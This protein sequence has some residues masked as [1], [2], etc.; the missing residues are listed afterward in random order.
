MDS[1]Q[2][3]WV[4]RLAMAHSLALASVPLSQSIRGGF[5]WH[6]LGLSLSLRERVLCCRSLIVVQFRSGVLLCVV[7]FCSSVPPVAPV[8]WV[9]ERSEPDRGGVKFSHHRWS[10]AGVSVATSRLHVYPQSPPSP[11]LTPLCRNNIACVGV[12]VLLL[13]VRISTMGYG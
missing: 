7:L 2:G 9:P 6:C 1:L 13:W 11:P 12:R 3:K 4:L 10:Q 8:P 5:S